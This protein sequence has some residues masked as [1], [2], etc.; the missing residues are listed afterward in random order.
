MHFRKL[1]E[2]HKHVDGIPKIALPTDIEG[3]PSC[4]VCKIRRTNRGSADTRQDATVVGQG[5]SMDWGFIF[6][7]SKTKGR[8]DKLCGWNGETSYLIIADHFSDYLW[9]LD[10]DGKA[11]PL[12]WLNRWFAQYAPTAAKF[13]YCFM[14]QGGE[15]ANNKDIQ[16]LLAYHRYTP[17]PTGGDASWQNAPGERPHLTIGYQLTTMLHGANL[18]FKL[19]PWAFNHCLLLH[20]IVLH[21]NRG[22]SIIR[23]G[24]KR[25][26]LAQ[27]RMFGCQV[28]VRPPGQRPSKLDPHVNVGTYLGPTATFTQA[29]YQDLCTLKFKTFAHVRYDEGMNGTATLTPNSRQLHIALGRPLPP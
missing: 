7:R 25:P 27:I 24:G 6:Q 28:F 29:H 9:G 1:S 19:W 23:I 26:D 5:I 15:L 3:Y 10:A 22:V 12:A 8:Y 16:A 18:Y 14:D 11:L 20:N 2:L 17:H 13:R 21:G 4:W